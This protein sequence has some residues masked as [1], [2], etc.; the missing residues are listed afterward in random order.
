MRLLYLRLQESHSFL[1]LRLQSQISFTETSGQSNVCC[2]F[3]AKIVFC[4]II[5]SQFDLLVVKLQYNLNIILLKY[6]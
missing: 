6:M 2:E 4:Q 1:F 3:T 5:T